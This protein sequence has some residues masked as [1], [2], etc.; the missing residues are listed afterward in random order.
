M[1]YIAFIHAE[2]PLSLLTI[3]FVQSLQMSIR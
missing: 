3:A 2:A 1:Y